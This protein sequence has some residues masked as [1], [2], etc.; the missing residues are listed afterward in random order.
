MIK[1]ILLL[2]VL[3]LGAF[4]ASAQTIVKGA[5]IIY[6]NG[7][8]THTVNV[9]VDAETAIDTAA[10]IWYER[11]R[12]G[13]GWIPAGF[14]IQK[15]TGSS[16]PTAAPLDKESEV[17]LNDVGSLYRWRGGAWRHINKVLVYSAGTGISITGTTITNT[18]DLS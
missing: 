14:R 5:G 11:S 10:G 7:A 12:D 1:K 4:Y 9:N 6:T 3:F 18:G 8:P 16:A 2:C 13:L 17:Q 15:F